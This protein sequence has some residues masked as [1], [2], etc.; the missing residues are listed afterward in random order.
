MERVFRRGV[1]SGK[2]FVEMQN[3]LVRA[4]ARI[5]PNYVLF[6]RVRRGKCSF[7]KN[8]KQ[9]SHFAN[10]K[11][12]GRYRPESPVDA[13]VL[14]A[15]GAAQPPCLIESLCYLGGQPRIFYRNAKMRSGDTVELRLNV[16]QVKRRCFR[17][18]HVFQIE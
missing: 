6:Q 14:P 17:S 16:S 3:R 7:C 12:T 1:P 9:L 18:V 11:I 13:S 4:D 2:K 5:N 8:A 10:V 15:H